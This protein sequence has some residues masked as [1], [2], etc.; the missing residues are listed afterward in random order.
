MERDDT[1]EGARIATGYWPSS[2]ADLVAGSAWTAVPS[3]RS[4]A[5]HAPSWTR[6]DRPTYGSWPAAGSTRSPLAREQPPESVGARLR[7][8]G[9][10][11]LS[12]VSR[13]V[14]LPAHTR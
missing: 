5:G 10:A 3:T 12:D 4:H 9:H 11:A 8:V 1:E 13:S 6:P 14:P 2:G 7:P